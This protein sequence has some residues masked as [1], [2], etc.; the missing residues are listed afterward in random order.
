METATTVRTAVALGS[1]LGDRLAN[2]RAACKAIVHLPEVAPPVS[3]SAIYET[4]PVNCE[5]GAGKFLNAVLEF[6][7]QGELLELLRELRQIE[8]VLGRPPRHPRNVSRKIDIDILYVGERKIDS[9][10]LKLPHPRMREREFVL[11][12]LADIRADLILSGQMITV[13]DL[14][15]QLPKSDQMMRLAETLI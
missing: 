5:Q 1:N 2:L 3:T 10:D 15:A 12:P 6:G 13:R 4:T 7:Y 8:K 11:R 14:L 9:D